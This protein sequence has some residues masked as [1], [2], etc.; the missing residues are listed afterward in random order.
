MNQL[1]AELRRRNVFRVAAAYLVVGWLVMQVVA[2]I[3]GAA[4][5]PDWADS[6]ALVLLVTGFPIVLF[7]AWAFELTPDG[8]KKTEAVDS[9][10][11]FKPLGPSDYV[12]I[13]GVVVVLGVAGFQMFAPQGNAPTLAASEILTPASPSSSP[14]LPMNATLTTVSDSSI[15]VLPFADLSPAGDQQYFSDGIAEEILNVLV[16]VDA[17]DVTSRT[18]A[19]QFKGQDLG[20]P[21]IAE[22]LNVRHVLE[23]SVRRSGDTLRIT[24]QLIDAT[25]DTHLWSETYDRPLTAENVFAIQDEIAGAIVRELGRILDLQVEAVEVRALTDDVT[26]YDLFLQ[27][28]TLYQ[29]RTQLDTV[30][31]LLNRAIEQDPQFAQAMA[32]RA[33]TTNLLDEYGYSDR[34]SE[35]LGAEAITLANEALAIDPDN[36]TAIAVRANARMQLIRR[37]EGSDDIADILS[38]FNRALAINP[39]DGS[40]LNWR[41]LAYMHL[42]Y[43]QEGLEDFQRCLEFEPLYAPCVENIFDTLYGLGR[44]D[45]ALAAYRYSLESGLMTPQWT[46]FGILAHFRADL[47]FKLGVNQPRVLQ[48]YSRINEIYEAYLELDQDHSELVEHALH[49]AEGIGTDDEILLEILLIPLGLEDRLVH[50]VVL[51]QP[52]FHAMRQLDLFRDRVRENG[53]LEYWQ[54]YGFPPQ[55]RPVGDDDFECD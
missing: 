41:G 40:A 34:P 1:L 50:T 5:L 39:R 19:F 15:A 3:G 33:G 7:I 27:A 23:G 29:S 46:S 2:T 44:S 18:S 43:L 4:G 42:G 31:E 8:M 49:Y 47:A 28:R 13:A 12:L 51:W 36:A 11:G 17:L 20:I 14:D 35:S 21:Q 37:Y 54:E 24:A 55:C 38:E 48:R 9:P 45:E 32:L 25:T 53:V 26:A 16:R 22:A 10:T 30:I 52:E 6:L